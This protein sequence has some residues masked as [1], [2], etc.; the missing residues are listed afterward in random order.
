LQFSQYYSSFS[1]VLG[2]R[3]YQ[4]LV[5]LFVLDLILVFAHFC[6]YI[7]LI[8]DELFLHHRL[9][10]ALIDVFLAEST[11]LCAVQQEFH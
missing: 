7:C 5:V 10:I 4:L 6:R 1:S 3:P 8:N 11:E 2:F 9:Y